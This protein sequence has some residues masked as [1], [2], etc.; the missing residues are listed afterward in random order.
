MPRK[1]KDAVNT[2]LKG[3]GSIISKDKYRTF[4]ELTDE[5]KDT[6]LLY[7][8]KIARM[9]EKYY[10][11]FDS[12][13]IKTKYGDCIFPPFVLRMMKLVLDYS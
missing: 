2:T 4:S 3:V 9:Q 6:I 12:K 8:E 11:T 13:K 1:K 10:T 7:E 5:E